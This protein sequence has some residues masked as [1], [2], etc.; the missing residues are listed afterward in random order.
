MSISAL[1]GTWSVG[2][3]WPWPQVFFT[4]YYILAV[5]ID[6]TDLSLYELTTASNVLTATK[7]ARLGPLVRIDS[8]DI[9]DF[10]RYYVVAIAGT[11]EGI[12]WKNMMARYPAHS[13]SMGALEVLNSG[14][15]PFGTS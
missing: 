15:V 7:V 10:G 8:V 11:Y 9:A 14:E 13:I 1:S 4:S 3:N 6:G 12:P 5:A 2:D